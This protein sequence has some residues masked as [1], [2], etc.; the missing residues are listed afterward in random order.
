MSIRI[1]PY[2][3][4][5]A[6]AVR[7]FNRRLIS[8]GSPDDLQF[9]ET[10]DP[11]WFPRMELFVAVD[12][13]GAGASVRGGYILRRQQF[14]LAGEPV[15][16][17]HYRLPLSEG[18]VNRSYATLGLRLVR[19][20][21]TREPLLYALGMGGWNHPLPKMLKRLHWRMCSVP[22][23]LK[24]VRPFSFLRGI[25]A[26]RT[27]PFRRFLLD[28]AAFSGVGWL[29]LRR[30]GHARRVPKSR[31]DT[32]ASFGGWA[33]EVFEKS[34]SAYTLVA[35]RDAQLGLFEVTPPNKV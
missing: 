29:G 23:L 9:P 35:A 19:D 33:D 25:G 17:A 21:L 7:E 24:V 28:A 34:R 20:A 2:T 1:V 12:H 22:F 27:T 8:G 31:S 15:P 3:A 4:A 5:H 18:A 16:V 14:Y 26:L 32:A 11:G 6:D 13:E 10:P 30:M